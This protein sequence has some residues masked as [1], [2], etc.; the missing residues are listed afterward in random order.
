ML[1]LGARKQVGLYGLQTHC[2]FNKLTTFFAM[3]EL[4]QPKHGK[5]KE[6]YTP[7]MREAVPF[8]FALVT[9]CTNEGIVVCPLPSEPTP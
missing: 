7:F 6:N 2:A 5:C 4:K 9:R 1:D 8:F 3:Q